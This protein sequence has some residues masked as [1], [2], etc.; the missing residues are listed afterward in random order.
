LDG[1]VGSVGEIGTL[2]R[3]RS[4]TVPISNPVCFGLA[5]TKKVLPV[6]TAAFATRQT[7]SARASMVTLAK[8]AA[9]R[10][11]SSE[12]FRARA[13]WNVGQLIELLTTPPPT[14]DPAPSSTTP[15]ASVNGW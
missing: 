13:W 6:A 11:F 1:G 3:L 7:A 4:S 15:A 9:S 10:R 8:R 2:V 12:R 14:T 5:D